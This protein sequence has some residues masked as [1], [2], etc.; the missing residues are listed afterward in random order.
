MFLFAGKPVNKNIELQLLKKVIIN[1]AEFTANGEVF[2]VGGATYKA[3]KTGCPQRDKKSNGNGALMRVLPLAFV[4]CT[5]DEVR[6]VSDI[7]HGHWIAK[8]ACVIFVN[9]IKR[10]L[11]QY[12]STNRCACRIGIFF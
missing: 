8:E 3:L 9:T 11:S 6:E 4:D 2:D 7:T 12:C 10:Y 5:D 1:K